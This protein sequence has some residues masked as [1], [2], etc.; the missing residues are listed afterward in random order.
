LRT[1]VATIDEQI[2]EIIDFNSTPDNE[3][4]DALSDALQQL[5]QLI[6]KLQRP[7]TNQS[8][9][10][11]SIDLI[12]LPGSPDESGKI[13]A[14]VMS[15]HWQS[16]SLTNL[17]ALSDTLASHGAKAVLVDT[18]FLPELSQNLD[19]LR[20]GK[21][22]R[23]GLFLIS[24]H[25][26]IETRLNAMR[27]GAT[28]LFSK[29]IDMDALITS[30]RECI[31]PK[32]KP[33]PRVLI[34]EDDESQAMFAVNLLQKGR[35]ETLAITDPLSVISAVW[36]FQP[37]LILMDLYMP[38]ADGIELT[39]LIRQRKAS[40]AIPIVFL[41]GEDDLEKKLLALQAG[42]DDFLNKP[43]RPQQLLATV[44]TRIERARAI[45]AAAIH[46]TQIGTTNLADRRALLSRLGLMRDDFKTGEHFHG[47]IVVSLSDLQAD[48][49]PWE[50]EAADRYIEQLATALKPLLQA[51]DFLANIGHQSLAILFRRA[52]E[53]AVETLADQTY[54]TISQRL[55]KVTPERIQLGI[56][57]TL[58][59]G[60]TESG[61]Q[62]LCQA[63]SSAASAYQQGVEGYVLFGENQ[64]EEEEAPSEPQ[65]QPL[66]QFI[67]DLQ[68][69]A[70][71]LIDNPFIC[72][73]GL[74]EEIETFELVP[75][76]TATG[77]ADDPYLSA[78]RCGA[79]EEL[80][81]FICE[82]AIKR[83]GEFALQGRRVRLIFR[84]SASVIQDE[85]YIDFIKDNLRRCQIVGTGL[86]AD[87]D[88][89]SLAADLKRAQRL[90][91]ELAALGIGVTLSNFACNETAYKVLA[92]LRAEAVRPHLSLLRA[93][94]QKIQ[95]ISTQ[96]HS[97]RA[98]IILP[99][100][101]QHSHIGLQWSESA[102]YVQAD[103]AR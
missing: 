58:L 2:N 44:K 16:L 13:D 35:L 33:L 103:F 82:H 72:R 25:F 50:D 51:D 30:L 88:L 99:L 98:E 27:A 71:T 38:G 17:Q 77:E 83:L 52:A 74:A 63:E 87:F 86:M 62:A 76:Y 4:I 43:V 91:G 24:D 73:Q 6:E 11:D 79:V 100:V 39:R 34:V 85:R 64:P 3:Q 32:A 10:L 75:Q 96:I 93:D 102:D 94:A 46:E 67:L 81:R 68:S 59:D 40:V 42:A 15:Q 28:Q 101:L 31:N 69:G 60:T 12:H 92:Y 55:K 37:D 61:Y 84:Q 41:S 22:A 90:I 57:L 5:K 18:R 49:D 80:D 97:L 14:A 8:S 47:L 1:L 95:H 26:D 78:A 65:T 70:V 9:K 23:P 66:D 45:T 19:I 89:P 36:R 56:G 48:P 21:H 29:P 7:D 20:A 54:N 53:Q